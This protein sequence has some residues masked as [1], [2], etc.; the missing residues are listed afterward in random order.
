MNSYNH[1]IIE[2]NLDFS[3]QNLF[4][5]R[6]QISSY[7]LDEWDLISDTSREAE[8]FFTNNNGLKKVCFATYDNSLNE[9]ETTELVQLMNT[10][11]EEHPLI[12]EGHAL[13]ILITPD[14]YEDIIDIGDEHK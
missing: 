8:V 10:F 3:V 11:F 4:V 7:I 5:I 2:H 14:L 13:H 9:A 6:R 12:I 1:I